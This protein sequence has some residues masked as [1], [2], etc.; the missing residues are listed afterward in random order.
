MSKDDNPLRLAAQRNL[1][2]IYFSFPLTPEL[3]TGLGHNAD[4]AGRLVAEGNRVLKRLAVGPA[5]SRAAP[6]RPSVD[7]C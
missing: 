7:D 6:S 1:P 3:L 4:E 5:D 2:I